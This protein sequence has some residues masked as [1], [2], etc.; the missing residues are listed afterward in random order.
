MEYTHLIKLIKNNIETKLNNLLS[1]AELVSED[2]FTKYNFPY[3]YYV[4]INTEQI[5]NSSLPIFKKEILS[6]LILDRNEKVNRYIEN[7]LDSRNINNLMSF[8]KIKL[9]DITDLY[10][11]NLS[12]DNITFILRKIYGTILLELNNSIE[13][14]I[15]FIKLQLKILKKIISNN[16]IAEEYVN[17]NKQYDFL[18]Y[19]I[20]ISINELKEPSFLYN[21]LIDFSVEEILHLNISPDKKKVIL[22]VLAIRKSH[23]NKLVK[24]LMKLDIGIEVTDKTFSY[25]YARYINLHQLEYLNLSTRKLQLLLMILKNTFEK[26]LKI[27][28][29]KH[30][31][32]K[33]NIDLINIVFNT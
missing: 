27:L 12:Y 7:L 11:R 10:N 1:V 13:V 21:R 18:I 4:G 30:K 2:D 29:I 19:V 33:T 8:D 17:E 23:T 28:L 31:D 20:K 24:K 9:I 5:I 14:D 26:E 3:Y 15:N 16:Y 25:K 32:T 6:N 22:E